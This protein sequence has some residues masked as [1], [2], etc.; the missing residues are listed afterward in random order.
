MRIRLRINY[1]N[2]ENFEMFSCFSEFVSD[3]AIDIG[4]IKENISIHG[5][6]SSQHKN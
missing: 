3:N 4:Q 5:L 1:I 6:K 2:N